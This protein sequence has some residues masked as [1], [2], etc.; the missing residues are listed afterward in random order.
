MKKTVRRLGGW[1]VSIAAALLTVQPPNRLNAQTE[2]SV[3]PIMPGSTR[4]AA[5][6]GAGAAL[7]GDAGAMFAN[8]A[9]TVDVTRVLTR[10]E[11]AAVLADA[12]NKPSDH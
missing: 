10:R 5:L 9:W 11:L 2:G 3:L 6:G 7:V 8:P 1:A 4:S 12:R